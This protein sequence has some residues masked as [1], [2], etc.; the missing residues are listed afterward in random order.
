MS[1]SSARWLAAAGLSITLLTASVVCALSRSHG[2]GP[3]TRSPRSDDPLAESP[4]PGRE[5][6]DLGSIEGTWEFVRLTGVPLSML[7][8]GALRGP[9]DDIVIRAD[10]SFRWGSWEGFVQ[11]S[12]G[13]FGMFVTRPGTLRQRF[14][15]YNASV[16]IVIVAGEMQ[17]WL[18]DLGQDRDIDVGQAQEDIDSPDLLF[19]RAVP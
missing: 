16:G 19:R 8:E 15:R 1:R 11:A 3:I 2:D 12:A 7:P 6:S 13:T 9:R 5:A 10:G 4:S 14:D 18:P 17:I